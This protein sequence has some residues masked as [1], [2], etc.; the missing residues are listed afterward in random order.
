MEFN[1]GRSFWARLLVGWHPLSAAG[2]AKRG[3][4]LFTRIGDP[5]SVPGG[6]R[7]SRDV[8]QR[9]W[10]NG[11][12]TFPRPRGDTGCSVTLIFSGTRSGRGRSGSRFRLRT[13]FAAQ[14]G[15]GDPTNVTP[16]VIESI[17]LGG[18][19][20]EDVPAAVSNS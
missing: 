14:N 7:R 19:R 3:G 2:H 5:V 1:R 18:V 20:F 12:R 8:R 15:L 13:S 9:D 11:Q 6:N 16:V 4:A 10:S 17:E